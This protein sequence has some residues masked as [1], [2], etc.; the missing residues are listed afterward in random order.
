MSKNRSMIS[1]TKAWKAANMFHVYYEQTKMWQKTTWLGIPCFKFPFD[2]WNLQEI[3]YDTCPD[4]IIE[5]GTAYGGSAVFLA[6]ILELMGRGRV[7]TIDT[8]DKY[9]TNINNPVAKRLWDSRVLP[10]IGDSTS[11]AVINKL[12]SELQ[13][14][15]HCLVLLDSWHRKEH[16]LRELELYSKYVAFH[17]YII[18]EDTHV[19]GNPV[20]WKWG[21]GPMEAVKEFLET[22]SDFVSDPTREKFMITCNP[23]GFLQR[24]R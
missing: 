23:L 19:N 4:V 20:P 16:V 12:D 11:D 21:A 9:K 2:T 6:S 7:I 8:N 17:S 5:T 3:I 22:N 13:Y 18:V 15:N 24:I 1:M 10:I 14:D